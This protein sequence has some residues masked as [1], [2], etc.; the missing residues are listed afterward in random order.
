MRVFVFAGPGAL[1]LAIAAW[2]VVGDRPWG[3]G[4]AAL[5][6]LAAAYVFGLASLML[7]WSGITKV[8][9]RETLL[10]AVAWRGDE[11]VLDV[12]CGRGLMLVGA[13][14]RLSSGRAIGIDIWQEADQSANTAEAA[15]T[16]AQIEGVADRID[17][18]TADMRSLPFPD[19]SFDLIVSHWAVHNV[20]NE[21]GRAA[22]LSEMVRVL[23]PEG[24]I[25]LADIEHRDAY[26]ARLADLGFTDQ[27]LMVKPMRDAILGAIS[28]GSFRPYA[29]RARRGSPSGR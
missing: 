21:S 1:V 2:V 24:T 26:A 4:L 5:L 22:A 15:W 19:G 16:N 29:I 18:Q 8:R 13:A 7:F 27:Q 28:F 9:E 10:D 20:E 11:T 6:T 23:R 25:I 17:V 14:K 12:G 3:A